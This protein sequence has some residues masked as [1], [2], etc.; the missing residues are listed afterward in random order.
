[1]ISMLDY[2][3]EIGNMESGRVVVSH[4]PIQLSHFS[5]FPAVL[6]LSLGQAPVPLMRMFLNAWST[7]IKVIG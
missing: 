2:V 7:Q 3:G 4:P 6:F 5:H 1:M